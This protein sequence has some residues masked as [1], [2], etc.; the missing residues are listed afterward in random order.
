MKSRMTKLIII[1]LLERI[2]L[3][4]NFSKFLNNSKIAAS[5]NLEIRVDLKLVMEFMLTINKLIQR[6]FMELYNLMKTATVKL[7]LRK[8]SF[9]LILNLIL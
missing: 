3:K 2:I 5:F 6:N 4:L 9:L 7:K 8:D 1:K